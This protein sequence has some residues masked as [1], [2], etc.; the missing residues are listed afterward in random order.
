MLW[1]LATDGIRLRKRRSGEGGPKIRAR[2][3]QAG[4]CSVGI[5]GCLL[6]GSALMADVGDCGRSQDDGMD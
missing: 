3:S 1:L 5:L 2:R 4:S 6:S